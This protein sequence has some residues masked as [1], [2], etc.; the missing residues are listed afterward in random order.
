MRSEGKQA[1]ASFLEKRS[2]KLLSIG[3]WCAR[4]A[5]GRFFGSFFKKELSCPFFGPV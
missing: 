3:A 2:K 4:S 1:S 5:R